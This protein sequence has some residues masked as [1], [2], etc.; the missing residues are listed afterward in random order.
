MER[1]NIE[2]VYKENDLLKKEL[3]NMDILLEENDELREELDRMKK[4]SFDDRHR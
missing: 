2:S 4:M 3:Q 1:E